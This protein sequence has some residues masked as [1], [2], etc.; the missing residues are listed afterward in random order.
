VEEKKLN[1]R[2][3]IIS[4]EFTPAAH[5]TLALFNRNV[6][7]LSY[8]FNLEGILLDKIQK[9]ELDTGLTVEVQLEAKNF[10]LLDGLACMQ[11][12]Y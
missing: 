8:V 5:T 9:G 11:T 2:Q 12:T 6:Q 3:F 7:N 4:S 10:I 1:S